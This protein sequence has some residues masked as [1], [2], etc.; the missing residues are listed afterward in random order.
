MESDSTLSWLVLA[1]SLGGYA[2]ISLAEASVASVRRERVQWLVTQGA[3][4]ASALEALH[5]T[6]MGPVGALSLLR[7]L[8]VASSLLA[9]AALAATWTDTHW[10]WISLMALAVLALLGVAYI[11]AK[12]VAA[13]FG[14][15]IA[16]GVARLIVLLA[17]LFKPLLAVEAIVVRLVRRASADIAEPSGEAMPAELGISVD[18]GGEPLDE[19]EVRMIRGVVQLDKTTAREIMVPRVDMVAAE[20]GTHLDQLALQMVQS[21][22]S[23]MP[24]YQGSLDHV[25]GIAYARDVLSNLS[26]NQEAPDTLMADVIRPALFIPESKT[27]EELLKEFQERRIHIAIAIDEYGGVSGLV[28]IEDLLEEIVGEIQDEFDVG[29][30]EIETVSEHEILMDARVSI[31]QLNEIFDVAVEGDGF[32]TVGGFVYQR[33]G[34][35]P[36]SGDTVEYD[37]LKIEVV[38]TVGRRLKRLRVLKSP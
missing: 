34:K 35:I 11:A 37:S 13:A 3:R 36:S 26:S 25:Q 5:S 38:S 31:D 1:I 32:D 9:G 15:R 24:I 8:F 2:L 20:V 23:R 10:G 28:T 12:V 14:E 18:A 21:G 6:R 4:G 7:T 17:W 22:H 27:L 30:S 33:L 16:L 29:G 19:R